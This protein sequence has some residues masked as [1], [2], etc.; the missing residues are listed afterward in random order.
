M[1]YQQLHRPYDTERHYHELP[2]SKEWSPV[3]ALQELTVLLIRHKSIELFFNRRS[4]AI[5]LS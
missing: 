1:K 2:L 3:C 5:P 4:G